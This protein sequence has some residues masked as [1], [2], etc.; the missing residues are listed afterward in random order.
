LIAAGSDSVRVAGIGGT[1][2]YEKRIFLCAR[3]PPH[4]ETGDVGIWGG[5]S[6]RPRLELVVAKFLIVAAT[7]YVYPAC[8]E[9]AAKK[10]QN[11]FVYTVWTRFL[12]SDAVWCSNAQLMEVGNG[13]ALVQVVG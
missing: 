8:K 2:K 3:F 1:G 11:L 4:H 9:P 7:A 10:N 6:P 12:L 13:H 5:R